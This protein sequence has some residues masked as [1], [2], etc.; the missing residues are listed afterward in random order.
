MNKKYCPLCG[1]EKV[2][3]AT[4][5]ANCGHKFDL[6]NAETDE[7]YEMSAQT[8][9]NGNYGGQTVLV[10]TQK[11]NENQQPPVQAQATPQRPKV[12]Y[13][14]VGDR[15]IAFL[16]DSLIL[17]VLGGLLFWDSWGRWVVS[18]LAGLAY[19]GLMEAHYNGG[20]Q[21]FGKKIMHI[22]TVDA[23]TLQPIDAKQAF[24]HTLGKVFFLPLDL[25]IGWIVNEDEKKSR[26]EDQEQIR[27]T[28]RIAETVVIKE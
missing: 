13:A 27:M 20:G 16:I 23:N 2:G 12:Q 21:T 7:E 28:Q 10:Q 8:A 18:S 5:C 26:G 24:L 15:I 17:S 3:G 6:E 14:E 9:F 11:I 1:M 22:R 19:F 25:I 4:F